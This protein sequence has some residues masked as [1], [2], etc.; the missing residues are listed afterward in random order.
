MRKTIILILSLSLCIASY[1]QKI[2][3][4][5]KNGSSNSNNS[6]KTKTTENPTNTSEMKDWNWKDYNVKYRVPADFTVTKSDGYSFVATNQKINLSIYPKKGENLTAKT[7][8]STLL[9]WAKQ[10]NVTG[11][12]KAHYVENLKGYQCSYIDGKVGEYPT[13]LL[14]L[15]NP[16][17]PDISLYIWLSYAAAEYDTAV[18]ILKSFKPME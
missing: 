14:L 12:D 16:N 3:G 9:A 17:N 1:A 5:N 7:M 10:N 11:F 18:E 15:I 8:E 2:G 4:G 6:N 13:S